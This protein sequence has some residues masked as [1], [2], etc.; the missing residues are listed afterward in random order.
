MLLKYK[1]LTHK[2]TK[3]GIYLFKAKKQNLI[4]HDLI[5]CDAEFNAMLAI[6]EL[7]QVL[8]QIIQDYAM[9]DQMNIIITYSNYNIIDISAFYEGKYYQ[10]I[11]NVKLSDYASEVDLLNTNDGQIIMGGY[12]GKSCDYEDICNIN[13][14]KINISNSLFATNDS[15]SNK[16]SIN[17]TEMVDIIPGHDIFADERGAIYSFDP[18]GNS[19]KVYK[20]LNNTKWIE[21]AD[22]H[23]ERSYPRCIAHNNK[24]YMFGGDCDNDIGPTMEYYEEG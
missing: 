21:L 5:Q 16:L 8:I 19:K 4:Y 2:L 6:I 14:I 3:M 1:L 11:S 23:Y 17:I 7:P 24:I 10:I 12:F 20:L 9:E 15:L 13:K 18:D 22:M